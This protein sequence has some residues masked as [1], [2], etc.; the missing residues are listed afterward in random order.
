MSADRGGLALLPT[1]QIAPKMLVESLKFR[2]G[3]VIDPVHGMVEME[4]WPPS[5]AIKTRDSGP[6]R[7][8]SL[9][10]V[11]RSAHVIP[12]FG[13]TSQ[14]EYINNPIDWDQY[15]TIY[16]PDFVNSDIHQASKLGKLTVTRQ[17]E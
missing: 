14:I 2:N 16:D 8:Y 11:V 13:D 5:K 12:G 3:G 17:I 1:L 10:S 9:T 7:F 15:N 6:R 4:R